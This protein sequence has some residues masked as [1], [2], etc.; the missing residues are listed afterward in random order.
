MGETIETKV[1]NLFSDHFGAEKEEL[2]PS[3][4]LGK[5]LNLSPLEVSDF[6]VILEN[7]FHVSIP[8]EESEKF[9]TLADIIDSVVN[10]GNFT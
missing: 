8:K 4:E 7:I 1:L 9:I 3:L 10:Y 2:N 6:L 5:D